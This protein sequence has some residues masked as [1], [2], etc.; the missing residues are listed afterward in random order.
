MSAAVKTKGAELEPGQSPKLTT[1]DGKDYEVVQEGLARILNL[2]RSVKSAGKGKSR[3]GGTPQQAVFYNP[4]QQFNRD[5]SVLVIRIFA[6][7]LAKIRKAR[8]ER[9]TQGESNNAG[10]GKKRKRENA[11]PEERR[12][13]L[14]SRSNGQLGQDEKVQVE[15]NEGARKNISLAINGQGNQSTLP[16]V[17]SE[18]TRPGVP[19]SHSIPESKEEPSE[20]PQGPR[21]SDIKAEEETDDKDTKP[22]TGT[23]RILDALSATGLRA[24]RYAK[25]I[26]QVTSAIANDLSEPATASIKLNVHHNELVGKVYATTG[27]ALTHMYR[28]AGGDHYRFPDGGQGRYEVIDLDPYGTA[29][30]FLDAAVQALGDGGLLCVTCTDSG[31]FASVG[32]LEKTYSQYGGL[33]FKGPQSHEVGLRLILHTIATSAARYGLAIEPL[34]S[35]SIDFYARVFVRIRKSPAEVKFLAGKTMLVYNCDQGCGA[36]TTQFLAQNKLKKDKK[37]GHFYKFIVSQAPSASPHCEHCG[38]KTHL[39][40]PMWGGPL[41]N[42]HFIQRILDVLPSLDAETYATI[43]RIEGMLSTALD[44]TLLETPS[45]QASDVPTE[46]KP[47]TSIIAS[48]DPSQPDRYPFFLIPSALAKV[49]HCAAPSHASICGAFI[50]LGYRATRSHTKPGSIRTDAPWNVIWEVMREWVRQK[51]PVKEGAIVKNTPGWGIMKHDRS[52]V[53]VQDLKEELKSIM[54]KVEDLEAAKTEIGA[55]LY[56]ASKA[57]ESN[58][59]GDTVHGHPQASSGGPVS[60]LE[61]VFDE[62]LGK[63]Y[64]GKRLV[65]YQLNPRANWGPMTRAKGGHARDE[66]SEGIS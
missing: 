18:T 13:V 3:D 44:E 46:P 61:V 28:V 17:S 60:K 33:P 40:G 6:E 24:L 9:R 4:I 50:D 57:P 53:R 7:D 32:Y 55:A 31:V 26:P 41:H 20:I 11:D 23:F 5:L 15:V 2:R 59:A 52:R 42:P 48:L 12:P 47:E 64:S 56:R 45:D 16:A 39:S 35:L 1:Y 14:E 37:E 25:E 19:E 65:R 27:N 54:E 30:P 58:G 29:A 66:A 49:L 38:F 8:R 34:V 36:W 62:E 43:P 10:K 63:D 21:S 51:A 22:K